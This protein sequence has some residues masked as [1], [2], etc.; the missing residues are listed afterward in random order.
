MKRTN[1]ISVIG[2]VYESRQNGMVL[3]VC[4]IT[5]CLGVGQHSGVEPKIKVVYETN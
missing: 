5:P 1:K 2:F 4:G 3:D